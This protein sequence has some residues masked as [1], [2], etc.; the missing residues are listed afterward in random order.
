MD[1]VVPARFNQFLPD[2]SLCI[3]RR[4]P[5]GSRNG[6]IVLGR[7]EGFAG[8]A[9]FAVIKLYQSARTPSQDSLGTAQKIVLS[10]LNPN[11]APIV[12]TEGN[13]FS[14]LGIFEKVIR[15]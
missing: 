8:D 14:I 10:S 1:N 9:P 4:D 15:S 6:K 3:F 5:G 2:G 12:L 7:I 13:E 11:H